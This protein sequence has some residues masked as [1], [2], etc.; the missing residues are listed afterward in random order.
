MSETGK[1]SRMALGPV[2]VGLFCLLSPGMM[3]TQEIRVIAGPG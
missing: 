2:A 3:R 1:I